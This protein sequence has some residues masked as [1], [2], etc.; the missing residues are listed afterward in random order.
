MNDE[1]QKEKL[2]QHF[3]RRVTT[4]ARVVLDTWQKIREDR[5]QAAVYRDELVSATDKLVRYA[6]RFEMESHAAAAEHILGLLEHWHQSSPLEDDQARQLEDATET[7]RHCTQR[8]TDQETS[9]TPQQYRRTP[10]YIALSNGEMAARLIR[11]LEF[12]GF[13]ASAFSSASDLIEACAL[14]KP[15]TILMDVNFGGDTNSG[16]AT[17][18]QLQ[19]QHDTPIPIIF[20][21]DEDGSIETRLR[22]SRCG[23]EEF[24]YPAVDPGQ[25]IE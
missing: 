8:R 25:L 18:E 24:F 9:D 12:F 15:E 20:M 16:I 3:A 7:L 2:R 1:S 19:E 13:R 21:S 17:V 22:A 23:G 14:S 4:Q 11:Q 5:D 10:V 6:K